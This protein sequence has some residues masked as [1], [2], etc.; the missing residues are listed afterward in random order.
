MGEYATRLSDGETIKIGTCHSMYYIRYEDRNKV[1]RD[2][3]TLDSINELDLRWRLP[4]PDEDDI[5]VGEYEQHDRG[6]MLHGYVVH[7][8]ETGTNW[9]YDDKSGM[10][11]K[12]TCHHGK[13][14]PEGSPEIIPQ[15]TKHKDLIELAAIK[16]TAEG[17]M[18][19]SRC[20]CCGE[21]WREPIP[22]VLPYMKEGV[23]KSRIAAYLRAIE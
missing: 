4:F 3:G 11:F 16:N 10:R 15:I 6:A 20:T 14:L 1:S 13:Q 5:K 22:D 19:V 17:L 18:A 12:V 23:L 2:E 9:I 21:M 7:D 8:V